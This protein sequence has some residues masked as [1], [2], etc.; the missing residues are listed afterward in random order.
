M[1][2]FSSFRGKKS[3]PKK[4]LWLVMQAPLQLSWKMNIILFMKY[5]YENVLLKK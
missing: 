2:K 1:Q 5:K 4:S 3:Q